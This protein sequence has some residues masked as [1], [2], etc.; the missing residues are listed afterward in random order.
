[1]LMNA[2]VTDR[3]ELVEEELEKDPLAVAK[4]LAAGQEPLVLVAVKSGCS[5][6]LLALLLERGFAADAVGGSGLTALG[7][8]SQV[9]PARAPDWSAG[10][11]CARRPLMLRP[12][13]APPQPPAQQAVLLCMPGSCRLFQ[14]Q[15]MSEERCIAYAQ[16]L[17]AFGADPSVAGVKDPMTPAE[18]ADAN[19]RPRLAQL[20]RHW[21]G[22]QAAAVRLLRR[23]SG[24]CA[25]RSAARFTG[26]CLICIS[27][28]V[29]ERICEML[30]PLPHGL[31][32][33]LE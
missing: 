32:A 13:P 4:P 19:G 12:V 15:L 21:S 25:C 18:H 30:A 24:S 6:E 28:P 23:T 29:C 14:P 31:H 7:A 17:L 8:I 10:A 3:R 22:E 33:P 9:Q 27:S 16:W 2:I 5:P 20:L 26:S 11:A 1:M